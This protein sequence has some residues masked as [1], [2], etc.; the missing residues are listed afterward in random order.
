MSAIKF[1]SLVLKGTA[2]AGFVGAADCPV[3][4]AKLTQAAR[5]SALVAPRPIHT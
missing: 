2:T 5:R 3:D 1:I 4:H